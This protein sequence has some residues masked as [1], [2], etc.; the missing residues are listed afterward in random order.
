MSLS[1]IDS[2][3]RCPGVVKRSIVVAGHKTSVS[4]EDA[5]WRALRSI[6]NAKDT[7]LSKLVGQIDIERQHPN[8]FSAIRLFVLDSKSD[9]GIRPG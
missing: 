3:R 6:A 5:F 4:L 8:L 7:P 1:S 9:R 2:S